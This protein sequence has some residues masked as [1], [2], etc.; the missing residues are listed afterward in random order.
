MTGKWLDMGT[1]PV[2]EDGKTRYVLVWHVYQKC[3]V[4]DS[5]KARKNRFVVRWMEIPENWIPVSDRRPVFRDANSLGVV[6]AKDI[7]GD[8]RLRGWRHARSEE[9]ITHWMPTPEAP[10]D[11]NELRDQA[12]KA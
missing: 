10:A 3:M 4:Y 7:H 12:E 9:G 6:I 2:P 8:V 1:C 11:Q 5:R